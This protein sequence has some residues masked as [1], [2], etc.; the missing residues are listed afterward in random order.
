VDCDCSS[1]NISRQSVSINVCV[2]CGAA[3]VRQMV[4]GVL[5]LYYTT[6]FE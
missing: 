5:E 4:N 6:A 2:C 1:L 3:V